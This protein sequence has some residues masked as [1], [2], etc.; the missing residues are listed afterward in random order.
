MT[1][2]ERDA[3]T[4]SKRAPEGRFANLICW[5]RERGFLLNLNYFLAFDADIMQFGETYFRVNSSARTL[6]FLQASSRTS[7]RYLVGLVA[8]LTV[9]AEEWTTTTWDVISRARV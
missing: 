7:V 5:E 1:V 2:G 3:W 9:L 6:N 4:S 8:T